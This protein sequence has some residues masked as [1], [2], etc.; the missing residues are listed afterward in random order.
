M[1]RVDSRVR[2]SRKHEQ[3]F[4]NLRKQCGSRIKTTSIDKSLGTTAVGGIM[5]TSARFGLLMSSSAIVIITVGAVA[6]AQQPAP[7]TPPATPPQTTPPPAAP[8]PEATPPAAP[9][10]AAPAPEAAPPKATPPSTTEIPQITVTAPRQAPRRATAPR[11]AP[12]RPTVVT[13]RAPAPA[14]APA[15]PAAP[16]PTAA[17][18]QAAANQQVVQNIQNLDERRDTTILPKTG[19]NQTA[20]TPRDIENLPQGSNIQISDLVLQLPGVSQDS[21]NQGD[22]HIRNEHA[23][24]QY[25]INGILLPEGVSGFQ[26]FLETSFINQMALLTGVL[27]VE[28]GLRTTAILDI[29]TKSGQALA[30]GNV[31]AYGGSRNT[32]TNAFQYGGVA[33]QTEYFA[34]GRYYT[35]N[36]GL[37]NPT[38]SPDAIHDHTEQGRIFGY[39]S[40]LLDR[41]TRFSTILGV[42]EA[43]F[44]IPANPGQMPLG[45]IGPSGAIP[46]TSPFPSFGSINS[47]YGLSNL[48]SS[49][50]N[51]NQ[52][53]RN[54]YAVMAWQRSAGD[55]DVQL[56]YYSR[57]ADV[58]FVPDPAADLYFNN[59]A[60]D[61]YRSTFV[62]GVSGDASYRITNFNTVRAGFQVNGEETSIKTGYS[63][64][65]LDVNGN[66]IDAPFTILDQ[67]NKF[68]WLAG[69]Y[70]QDEWKI[71]NQLT[72]FT[73][74]RFD[75]MYQY[76]DANQV[77]P[78][79]NL[80]Y[81]PW[82]P[83][84]FHI[85]W[86]RF[87]TP[88]PQSEG[89]VFPQAILDN[90]TGG[91][92]YN[93]LGTSVGQIL[94]E[95]SSVSDVG[96]TQQLLPQCPRGTGGL[97][98]K[99]PAATTSCPSLEVGVDAYYKTAKDLIDDGQFGQAYILTAFNYERAYNWGVEGKMRFRYGGLDLWGNIARAEQHAMTVASNQSL[100]PLDTLSYISTHWINTDHSQNLTASGGI[101]Y[102]W[103]SYNPWIDGFKTSAT[104]IYGT[105]LRSGFANTDHV[106][107]YTQVN[108]GLSR[109]FNPWG[110]G[111]WF[112]QPMTV[113]FDIVNLL[114]SIYEI[115]EGSGIGVFAPQFGP[116]R[117]YYVGLSQKL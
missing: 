34:T 87:F 83:T 24:V 105:G 72:L 49:N 7:E 117:G 40:T 33:G 60:S 90:T 27:P 36:L 9:P 104:F 38:P 28:Y 71:T 48:D 74:A 4:R 31:S 53:E 84:V 47:V 106:S 12:A 96:V 43:R 35:S 15:A 75:Q 20:L 62:N 109:E 111:G 107:P 91:T 114:D 6:L 23:N 51:Q 30:G 46:F 63:V 113:R 64:E 41:D 42:S 58:H 59:V 66:P 80:T 57:F 37:D 70:L 95:R 1:P 25:R 89:R 102:L 10:P 52:Y 79:V 13:T 112:T 11:P 44:Q 100:F 103:T 78:R 110:S 55:V 93:F 2:Q 16:A 116:R 98:T 101:S 56:S 76:V 3:A 14:A 108:L 68:G 50:I 19:I 88:P 86:G 26:Q 17:Q 92:A 94:P 82:W 69:V 32:F 77:S 18:V 99:A 115:R 81:Q 5:L 8:P 97:F 65:P 73:G 21:T 67:S 29:T 85:G 54:G 39:T 45:A 61:V 22:F